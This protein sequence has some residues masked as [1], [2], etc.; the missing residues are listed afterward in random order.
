MERPALA[1]LGA[2]VG[3]LRGGGRRHP[4]AP[5]GAAG[6]WRALGQGSDRNPR[7]EPAARFAPS[8]AAGRCRP[9][10]AAMPRAPGPITGWPRAG[11]A[12]DL[13]RW[14]VAR[15]D[16]DDPDRRA[17]PRTGST[18]VRA[19]QQAAGR[20]L[21]RQGRRAAG[22]CCARCM[23]PKRR[24]R[25]RSSAA[26]EGRKVDLLLD[27]GTGTGRMLELLAG[28]YRRGIGIDSSRE[29]IAVARAKLRQAGIAHAQVR[30]GD[31]ANLDPAL[32]PRRPHRHPSGAALFRRSRPAAGAGRA[33]R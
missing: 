1:D 26:L 8:E 31:I 3:V 18:A 9:R 17:R 14:L 12:R 11:R 15:L 6:R 32:G 2:L 19:A 10:H 28:H 21:F 7:P 30:L 25:P 22:T 4:A 20:R 33:A 29:M 13:A 24:S 23:C 16:P 5:A 27:L